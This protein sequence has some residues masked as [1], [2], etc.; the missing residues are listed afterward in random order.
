V[1]TDALPPPG[2]IAELVQSWRHYARDP[3]AAIRTITEEAARAL[4][5]ARAGMWLLDQTAAGLVCV[6]LYDAAARRHTSGTVLRAFDLPAYFAAIAGEDAI[7]AADAHA[8][9]RI[10]ELSAPYLRPLGIGARLDATIRAGRRLAGVLSHEHVGPPRAW[11]VREGRD[12]VFLAALTE[13]ALNL[14]SPARR[15]ALLAA[16]IEATG[17][18]IL[19]TDDTRVIAFNQQFLEMW[20]IDGAA[21]RSFDAVCRHIAA[22]TRRGCPLEAAADA[23][24][25]L[26]ERDTLELDDGRLFELSSR[27]QLA[28]DRVVGRVWSF[29]DVTAQRRRDRTT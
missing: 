15:E 24:R 14:G 16:T 7:A 11:T 19:A 25:T 6:D 29:R 1:P 26:E 21:L 5:V 23:R 20:R 17:E 3:D 27:P 28:A 4:G 10:A 12:A 2:A 8:D 22:R 9:P 18:G 13:L